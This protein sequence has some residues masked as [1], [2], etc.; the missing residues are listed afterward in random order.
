MSLWVIFLKPNRGLVYPLDWVYLGSFPIQLQRNETGSVKFSP[1]R[2]YFSIHH[3]RIGPL[4]DWNRLMSFAFNLTLTSPCGWEI[5]PTFI[6][7]H[8]AN[9]FLNAFSDVVSTLHSGS[10]WQ[11][12]W[13]TEGVQECPAKAAQE[14]FELGLEGL[15]GFCQAEKIRR[16]FQ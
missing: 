1:I 8:L 16:E 3:E 7:Q 12:E 15:V 5:S 11:A 13:Q 9:V 4:S 14:E 6:S 10:A 2:C